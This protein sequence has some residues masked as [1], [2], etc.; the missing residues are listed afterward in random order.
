MNEIGRLNRRGNRLSQSARQALALA[1]G[2]GGSVAKSYFA[3][4]ASQRL[5]SSVIRAAHEQKN[6]DTS[7]NTTPPN[8]NVGTLLLLNG[9]TQGSTGNSRSGRRF[10][11]ERLQI[12]MEVLSQNNADYEDLFRVMV[13]YDKECRGA[14]FTSSDLFSVNTFG[15]FQCTSPIN[16]DNLDR[17]TII[18]DK[19]LKWHADTTLT[20][21]TLQRVYGRY[22]LDVPLNKLVKC[23]NTS[24]GTIA[25]IDEG[26]LYLFYITNQTTNIPNPGGVARVVFRDL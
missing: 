12:K 20:A 25:D 24:A 2:I 4:P 19:L 7:F 9:T 1:S 26:S 15:V 18:D 6:I 21:P 13:I 5:V 8:T 16:F 10:K 3:A 23:F 17:F 14:A 11:M 22:T